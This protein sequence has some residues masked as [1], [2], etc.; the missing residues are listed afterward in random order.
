MSILSLEVAKAA[1]GY[2]IKRFTAFVIDVVVVL[3]L[4]SLAYSITGKPDFI[5]VRTAMDTAK[6]GMPGPVGQALL[7]NVF[8]LFNAAYCQ[9]LFIGF[10]YEAV[11]QLFFSGATIGKLLMR[12][13]IVPVKPERHLAVHHSLMMVRSAVKCL[14]LFLFQGIPFLVA[15]LSMFTNKESRG[16]FDVFA[17]TQVVDLKRGDTI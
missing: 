2:R 15:C 3:G 17:R 6:S 11:M 9:T 5:A 10:V 4:V 7:N 1:P 12:F 14:F 13:R 8:A 16:G